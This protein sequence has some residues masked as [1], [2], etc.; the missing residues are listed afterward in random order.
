MVASVVP[1]MRQLGMREV[2]R[3]P[4]V[5]VTAGGFDGRSDLILFDVDRGF[6]AGLWSL[7]TIEDL[8]VEV[9]RTTR[10]SGDKPQGIA[11]VA[12]RAG[13]EGSFRVVG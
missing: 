12:A 9:G 1:G 10:S 5:R 13:R 2:E 6:R 3:L 7:R 4:G 11:G 8:F